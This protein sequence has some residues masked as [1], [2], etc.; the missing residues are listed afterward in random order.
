MPNLNRVK[1]LPVAEM[2]HLPGGTFLLI[3]S[4][5]SFLRDAMCSFFS[6]QMPEVETVLME[7]TCEMSDLTADEKHG[8]NLVLLHTGE[9][10]IS[11]PSV[12]AELAAIRAE[13][14]DT[15]IVL[16]GQRGDPAQAAAAIQAGARGYIPALI[17][18]EIIKHALPLVAGGGVF[19]PPFVYSDMDFG[20][21]GLDDAERTGAD[22]Q[23]PAAPAASS[24]DLSEFTAREIEV[25]ELLSA[26]L[27]N[28][29]IAYR[30]SLKEGTVKVHMRNVM[31]KLK[32]TSRT[33]AALIA[34]RVFV[35]G[36]AFIAGV[37]YL[38]MSSTCDDLCLVLLGIVAS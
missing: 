8:V 1:K 27:P 21:L 9:R 34:S 15:A 10:D 4:G 7:S 37:N 2:Q 36:S 20:P 18:S 29:V 30:L 32:V 33:Q 19:A 11:C 22:Q 12:R 23:T 6:T 17:S 38:A 24:G 35:S 3:M 25:L 16:M 5:R 31:R 13:L 26:G 28:K 14:P